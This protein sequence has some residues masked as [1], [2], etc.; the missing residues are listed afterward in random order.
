VPQGCVCSDGFSHDFPKQ[1]VEACV[2]QDRADRFLLR[3]G[4]VAWDKETQE[5]LFH[6]DKS[7]HPPSFLDQG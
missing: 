5:K 3:V 7:G 1:G 6:Q 4:Q 2:V